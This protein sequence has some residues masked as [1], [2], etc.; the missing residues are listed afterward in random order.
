M[1]FQNVLNL[2]RDL[3]VGGRA[4]FYGP[5]YFPQ[6]N[7]LTAHAGGGQA[8][9]TVL[10]WGRIARVT[11]A[12]SA[13]D[14]CLISEDTIDGAILWVINDGSSAI[15]IFPPVGSS[16]D[17]LGANTAYSL[18]AGKAIAFVRIGAAYY[19]MPR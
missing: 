2:L 9:G 14:S 17:A 11:T 16:I 3:T 1:L 19:S 7:G 13:G 18:A 8:A 10:L 5:L 6:Q 12:A 4:L 15:D